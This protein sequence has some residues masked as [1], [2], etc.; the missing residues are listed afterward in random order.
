M[1]L[2]YESLELNEAL[3]DACVRGD[4]LLARQLIARGATGARYAFG[5][6]CES[7]NL[8]LV[9]FLIEV[10]GDDRCDWD[11]GLYHACEKGHRELVSLML[12]KGA[13]D[14]NAA[15]AGA[16]E[17]GHLDLAQMMLDKGA[18]EF[19]LFG[20]CYCGQP[21]TVRFLLDVGADNFDAGLEGACEGGHLE[22]A[23]L[24]IQLGA[25]DV[26]KGLWAAVAG[27]KPLLAKFMIEMGATDFSAIGAN[28]SLDLHYSLFCGLSTEKK[29]L[30]AK[31]I[32]GLADYALEMNKVR[33]LLRR[34]L[35][36]AEYTIES[37]VWEKFFV[38]PATL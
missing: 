7:G 18:N 21:S 28:W 33:F 19:K 13:T 30:M 16:C 15:L 5:D 9:L 17:G 4:E 36:L 8:A 26:E 22:E 27:Q 23:K 32:V 29:R 3:Y 24:M 34:R 35:P 6:A 20:P 2:L 14:F 38:C 1:E 12:L 10:I 25:T 31:A 37:D 11:A